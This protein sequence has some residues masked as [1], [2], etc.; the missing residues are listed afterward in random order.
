MPVSIAAFGGYLFPRLVFTSC[1]AYQPLL[2][3]LGLLANSAAVIIGAMIVAPLM[4]PIVGMA[5]STAMGNRKL[6]RRSS[7]TV[8]KG[9]LLT[10]TVS[11]LVT[12]IIGLD[13]VR[14]RDYVA[15]QTDSD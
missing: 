15:G 2:P 7:F 8:L 9:I 10:I 5:Y 6:L 11:W 14:Y 4:G 3:T 1:W 12:S 13:T